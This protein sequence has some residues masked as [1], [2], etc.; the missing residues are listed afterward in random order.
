MKVNNVELLKKI[1]NCDNADL[2]S[3]LLG[4]FYIDQESGWVVFNRGKVIGKIDYNIDKI[5]F[6]LSGLDGSLFMKRKVINSEV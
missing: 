2:L 4:T 3:N 6:S 5:I 1:F